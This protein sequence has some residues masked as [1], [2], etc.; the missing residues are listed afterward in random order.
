MELIKSSTFIKS[1]KLLIKNNIKLANELS[2]TLILLSD[3]HLNPNLRTHK[4]K[5]V[6]SGS[7]SCRVNY[8]IRIVFQIVKDKNTNGEI[9]EQILLQAIGTHDNVY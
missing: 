9:V 5:G 3:N 2:E 4:L 1:A 7:L 6:L 8:E